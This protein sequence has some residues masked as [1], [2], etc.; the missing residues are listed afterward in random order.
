MMPSRTARLDVQGT[1]LLPIYTV[2]PMFHD[3]TWPT[4]DYRPLL[5][6]SLLL[7]AHLTCP[8]PAFAQTPSTDEVVAS[9]VVRGRALDSSN[10]RPVGGTVV[11]LIDTFGDTVAV[12]AAD[13]AG[14]FRVVAPRAGRYRL[15][16]DA[17]GY[18]SAESRPFDVVEGRADTLSVDLSLEA[19]PIPVA[20]I[21]V[22]ADQ[23]N[24]R[25]RQFFGM[26]PGQLRIRPVT[27]AVID[28]HVVRGHDVSEMMRW[29]Q[30]PNL[31]VLRS[32]QGPCYQYRGR[33]CMPVYLDGAR[34]SQRAISEIPLEMLNTAVVLLPSEAT[35]YPEGAVHLFTRGFMR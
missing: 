12:T 14:G 32:Q 6:G 29:R 19:A 34:M 24:R 28:D 17:L 18:R 9:Q 26:S 33:G 13:S 20:G 15:R 7:A 2:T 5:V 22:S 10:R 16:G 31:Q 35:A 8:L 4:T 30:I 11:R 27:Q 3:A 21:E 25:L 1:P 23:T